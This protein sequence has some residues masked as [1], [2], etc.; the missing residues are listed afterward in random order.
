MKYSLDYYLCFI[1]TKTD[2]ETGIWVQI[3]SLRSGIR[4]TGEEVRRMGENLVKDV[5]T[6]V[7]N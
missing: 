7:G 5:F 2:P 1:F 4:K 3:V 6:H